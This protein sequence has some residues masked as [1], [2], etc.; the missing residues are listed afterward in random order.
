[1][2]REGTVN[3][4]RTFLKKHDRLWQSLRFVKHWITDGRQEA[5]R[6]INEH[7]EELRIRAELYR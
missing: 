1:M 6:V 5:V 3:A 2:I 7:R 4:I